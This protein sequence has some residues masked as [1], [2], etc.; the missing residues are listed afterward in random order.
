M[1]LA[2]VRPSLYLSGWVAIWGVVSG[3]TAAATTYSHL[4]VIRF[5]L[6]FT[7]SPY[8]AGAMFLLSSWYTKKEVAVGTLPPH[9]GPAC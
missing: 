1:I 2:K 8:F 9:L 3:C 6:G 7:E 4:V 5:F